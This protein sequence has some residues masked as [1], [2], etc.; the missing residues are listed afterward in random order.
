MKIT[1]TKIIC[2]NFKIDCVVKLFFSFLGQSQEWYSL[3]VLGLGVET[4]SFIVTREINMAH[5]GRRDVTYSALDNE[6]TPPLAALAETTN[7]APTF[8]TLD[9]EH[10]DAN[11]VIIHKVPKHKGN[12]AKA[13][14]FLKSL[15]IV[16]WSILCF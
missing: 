8:V 9:H 14:C 2:M 3:S 16:S 1:L 12:Q 7:A 4:C 15:F 10:E 13:W 5:F 6:L 11:N